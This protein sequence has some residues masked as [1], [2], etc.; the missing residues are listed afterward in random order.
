MTE[1]TDAE[2]TVEPDFE[3]PWVCPAC[4]LVQP[5]TADEDCDRCSKPLTPRP[6]PMSAAEI[7]LWELVHDAPYRNEPKRPSVRVQPFNMPPSLAGATCAQCN[8]AVRARR[9]CFIVHVDRAKDEADQIKSQSH[10]ACS[11]ACADELHQGLTV[12]YGMLG[13]QDVKTSRQAVAAANGE[14]IPEEPTDNEQEE[15]CPTHP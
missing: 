15:Q 11:Q 7:E 10:L 9:D 1:T 8:A 5:D 2:P 3:N 14:P 6:S 4:G 12:E 13:V